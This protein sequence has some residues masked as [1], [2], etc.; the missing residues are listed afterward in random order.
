[1][2]KARPI[3]SR[4]TSRH[5]AWPVVT[6]LIAFGLAGCSESVT[7]GPSSA[8]GSS[9]TRRDTAI[10]H[11][12][13]DITSSGTQKLDANGD[14]H[15][16]V[17]IVKSGG[18]TVCRAYDLD[19]DG[20][21]DVWVYLDANGKVRRRETDYDRNGKIDEVTTYKGG[22]IQEKDRST[23]FPGK[24]D[25]WEFYKD[26]KLAS[27]QRDSNGDGVVDQWWEYPATGKAGC[28]LIHADING[29]GH[30]DPGATVD[31]CKDTNY[32]PPAIPSSEPVGPTFKSPGALPTEVKNQPAGA[33]NNG[34]S[35]GATGAM[36]ATN[37]A[38]KK[39]GK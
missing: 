31:I 28:P 34:A 22:V 9:V 20:K 23:M 11:E 18:R 36:P 38:G 19:S 37:A 14:G 2:K 6:A 13:C 10:V 35:S 39:G 5:T 16:D 8:N 4:R 3:G 21:I 7:V 17:Y 15:P 30:P 27:V 1:M 26:G 29:D 24:L 33:S 32:V 12:P 25:T